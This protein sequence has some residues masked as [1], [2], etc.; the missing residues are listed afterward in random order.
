[1]TARIDALRTRRVSRL[2]EDH[3]ALVGL[4][5]ELPAGSATALLGSN[6]AGKSTLLGILSTRLRPSEGTVVFGDREVVSAPPEIRALIGYVG[7]QTM[8]YGDLTA[9]ENLEF[10]G[11]LYGLPD[12]AGRADRM[13]DTVGLPLDKDRP[14]AGF[15]RGMAQRL[16]VARALLHDPAVL[17]LDEPFTGLDVDGVDRVVDLLLNARE[18]GAVVV[19][20]THN[21]EAAM[22]FVDRA[23]VL[24]RGRRAFEG[25]VDAA[26]LG[27]IYR[28]ARGAA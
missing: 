13:L 16:S 15:S 5:C 6:G 2:Y 21:L 8:L 7:H 25:G 27:D 28:D 20:A 14:A 26:T 17:L 24:R 22:R 19:V 23:L 18:G 10:Y 3:Y 9:R 12:I 1:M 4:D 11:R